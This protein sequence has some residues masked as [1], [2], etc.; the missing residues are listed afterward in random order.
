MNLR[1]KVAE[2][3]THLGEA[4]ANWNGLTPP[5]PQTE[6]VA[7]D[8][9]EQTSDLALHREFEILFFLILSIEPRFRRN[10][11]TVFK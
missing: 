7:P 9:K 3:V 10:P 8:F 2:A 4:A 6:I 1:P 11:R 5:C